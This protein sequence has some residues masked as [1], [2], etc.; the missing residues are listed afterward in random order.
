MKV[1]K[2]V[3]ILMVFVLTIMMIPQNVFAYD[4]ENS[5]KYQ[6]SDAGSEAVL[7]YYIMM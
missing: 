3:S 6:R 2:I 1:K 5:N 7:A 4:L